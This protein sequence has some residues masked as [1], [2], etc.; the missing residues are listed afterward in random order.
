M[1]LSATPLS[2][3]AIPEK[4]TLYALV[5]GI[6]AYE[7]VR[8]LRG[9]VGDAQAMAGYLNQ[10]SDFTPDLLLLTDQAAGKAAII[11][12]FRNHLTKAG[13]TDTVLFYFAG[14]GHIGLLTIIK[15]GAPSGAC[16]INSLT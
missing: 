13:P 2:L 3:S 16:L 11:D 1:N 4:P 8:A 5:V 6:G 14:H 9:P 7:R 12:G 15:T 10:L